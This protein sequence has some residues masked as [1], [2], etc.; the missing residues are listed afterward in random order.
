MGVGGV[1]VIQ[2]S[3]ILIQPARGPEGLCAESARAVAGR[4]CPHSGEGE[5]FLMGQLKF[6]TKTA[7]TPERKVKNWIPRWEINSHAEG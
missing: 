7:V 4:W 1:V 3:R 6:L 2:T 5:D